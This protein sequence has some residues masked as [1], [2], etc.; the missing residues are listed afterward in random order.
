MIQA[1]EA[2]NFRIGNIVYCSDTKEN[3][4]LNVHGIMRIA[5]K[6]AENLDPIEL[7]P[8]ILDKIDWNGYVKLNIGSYFKIDEVGHLFYRSDYT[9]I[10]IDYL[11]QLQN[12]YFA[13]TGK[14]ITY[15]Q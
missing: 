10:N 7:S 11:H 14:E 12:L 2:R 9:G 1:N 8:D 5:T 4:E 3:V 15:N 6:G 13:L